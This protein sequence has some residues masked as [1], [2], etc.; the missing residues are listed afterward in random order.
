M[1]ELTAPL[2]VKLTREGGG[3]DTAKDQRQ[4][5]VVVLDAHKNTASVKVTSAQY[6]DYLHLVKWDGQWVIL[7]VVWGC[8]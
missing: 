8:K 2:M 4:I 1:Q 3:K 5:E 6:I 7:N